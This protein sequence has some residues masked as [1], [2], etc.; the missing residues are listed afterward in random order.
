M[1]VSL[2][3]VDLLQLQEIWSRRPIIT[4]FTRLESRPGVIPAAV[5]FSVDELIPRLTRLRYSSVWMAQAAKLSSD[6]ARLPLSSFSDDV[7]GELYPEV[8]FPAAQRQ[9]IFVSAY[10]RF[11]VAH[12]RA[13]AEFTSAIL[14]TLA[15]VRALA[16]ADCLNAQALPLAGSSEWIPAEITDEIRALDERY[17]PEE[18]GLPSAYVI[19]DAFWELFV[20]I[21]PE[22]IDKTVQQHCQALSADDSDSVHQALTT[23]A[24]VANLWQ[25]SPSVVGLCYQVT[26]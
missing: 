25:R 20:K 10:S 17:L 4:A 12:Y 11:V 8:D 22:E 7:L 24:E 14:Q 26:D 23:L 5:N 15:D 13:S 3:I 6:P 9:S 16:S 18:P 1:L 21:T 19:G 2:D